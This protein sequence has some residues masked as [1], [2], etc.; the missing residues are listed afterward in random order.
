MIFPLAPFAIRGILWYQ[1]ESNVGRASEYAELFPAL[2]RSWRARWAQSALPFYFVQLPD[3]AD[4]D[5]QGTPWARLREAQA[6]ALA[7]PATGMAVAIDIG[8]PEILHPPNKQ[9][10]GR[11]LALIALSQ[12]HGAT[13]ECSG[14]QFDGAA[15]ADGLMRVHFRHA[16]SGL[17]VRGPPVRSLQ[18]AGAD[19]VF[20]QA[21]A[22]IDGEDLVVS[23]P[24]VPRPV[25]V[26]YAWTNEPRANLANGA[27][28]PA[29]P[30]RT[31]SW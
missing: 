5:P 12:I 25:A 23:C 24:A 7:L 10:V 9:E 14:P 11:R 26:R 27:G 28:L 1:G 16:K 19:R 8:D 13:A 15:A 6:A 29:G 17:S 18:L 22:T 3:F 30:F 21:M 2:I 20:H 4:H 31:D